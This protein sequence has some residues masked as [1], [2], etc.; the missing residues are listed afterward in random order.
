MRV[1]DDK[2]QGSTDHQLK[3][4]CDE[5]R[6]SFRTVLLLQFCHFW[7]GRQGHVEHDAEQ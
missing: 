7:A 2:H 4:I 1:F 6:Y 5:L 3:E